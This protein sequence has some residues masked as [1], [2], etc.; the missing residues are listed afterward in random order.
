MLAVQGK[1]DLFVYW[2]CEQPGKR[3]ATLFSVHPETGKISSEP[4]SDKVAAMLVEHGIVSLSPSDEF[5]S[6]NRLMPF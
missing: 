3:E 4:I 6:K 5:S 2:S 1:E